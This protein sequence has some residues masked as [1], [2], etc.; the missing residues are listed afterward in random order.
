MSTLYTWKSVTSSLSLHEPYSGN[1]LAPALSFS[2]HRKGK[3]VGV[4]LG[5]VSKVS[6]YRSLS[7]YINSH[8][9]RGLLGETNPS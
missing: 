5:A 6:D 8:S 2:G 4:F 7:S 3:H 9:L 1:A